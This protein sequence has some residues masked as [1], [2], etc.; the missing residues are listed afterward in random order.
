MLLL[1]VDVTSPSPADE[2]A[3][4]LKELAAYSEALAAKPRLTVLTKADLLP[5][6][7]RADAPQ[8]A[9]LPEAALISAQTGL[10]LRALM[11]SLW[12]RLPREPVEDV[13][14]DR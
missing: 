14:H 1:V 13:A 11:E 10:G 8:R 6:D 4:V 7:A 9:G 5:E 12:T 3:V 2:A